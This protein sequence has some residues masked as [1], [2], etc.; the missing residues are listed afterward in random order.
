MSDIEMPIRAAP[1]DHQRKAYE[2]A[3]LLFGIK[4]EG[5]D[6]GESSSELRLLW[7]GIHQVE[8]KSP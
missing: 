7:D 6:D 2:F 4:E 3:M 1:F 5:N 8:D